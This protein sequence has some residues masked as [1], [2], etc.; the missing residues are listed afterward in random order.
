MQRQTRKAREEEARISEKLEWE[1]MSHEDREF[2]ARVEIFTSVLHRKLT[3]IQNL[4]DELI[5]E[6]IRTQKGAPYLGRRLHSSRALPLLKDYESELC[7]IK[8]ELR[9]DC[10]TADTLAEL[11]RG[12][13]RALLEAP[14]Q[15][16]RL[17]T[18]RIPVTLGAVLTQW[19]SEARSDGIDVETVFNEIKKIGGSPFAEDKSRNGGGKRKR[20]ETSD[21]DGEDGSERFGEGPSGGTRI[22]IRDLSGRVNGGGG[23][24]T[25]DSLREDGRSSTTAYPNTDGSS[26]SVPGIAAENL[27]AADVSQNNNAHQHTRTCTPATNESSPA[28]HRS[29]VSTQANMISEAHKLR[30]ADGKQ[31]DKYLH[32]IRRGHYMIS[33][34]RPPGPLK[35]G[36]PKETM[37]AQL[38]RIHQLQQE[39]FNDARDTDPSMSAYVNLQEDLEYFKVRQLLDR[40]YY[41]HYEA[42][43]REIRDELR[44]EALA[45]LPRQ[46]A[47]NFINGCRDVTSEFLEL[48]HEERQNALDDPKYAV[49]VEMLADVMR[50]EARGE[51]IK[52]DD[53]FS[54]P[55]GYERALWQSGE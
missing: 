29:K 26:A 4:H 55:K 38:V 40:G 12:T 35:M 51:T 15:S 24:E 37:S 17:I 25:H 11:L 22:H 10:E 45:D 1:N 2:H 32:T 52:V 13:T 48:G 53:V 36:K 47:A 21:D 14:K 43:L 30:E 46:E 28:S 27:Q 8:E 9:F 6:A 54:E 18:N 5:Q 7:R 42:E 23:A 16:M 44:A 39:L 34:G 3:T 33:E 31:W 49:C 50:R 41:D 20:T 19:V